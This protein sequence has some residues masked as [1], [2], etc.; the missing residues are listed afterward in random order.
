MIARV[1]RESI[2]RTPRLPAWREIALRED[3]NGAMD[4]GRLAIR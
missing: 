1:R 4:S 2:A 3:G